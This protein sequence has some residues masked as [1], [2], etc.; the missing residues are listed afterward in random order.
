[1]DSL[2]WFFNS[3]FVLHFRILLLNCLQFIG[4]FPQFYFLISSLCKWL[5]CDIVFFLSCNLKW[6]LKI[7]SISV[8]KFYMYYFTHKCSPPYQHTMYYFPRPQI[9]WFEAAEIYFLTG[10]EMRYLI[11]SCQQGHTSSSVSKEEFSLASSSFYW[12]LVII[13]ASLSCRCINFH[14]TLP[15]FSDNIFFCFVFLIYVF[16]SF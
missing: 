10:L 8:I 13:G 5:T 4:F 3:L 14:I 12:L 16:S 15:P 2:F 9:Q 7:I 11:S 1:M 6:F